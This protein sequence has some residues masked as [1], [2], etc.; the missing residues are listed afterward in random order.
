M[1]TPDKNLQ[2][3]RRILTVRCVNNYLESFEVPKSVAD[4]VLL[5][6]RYNKSL[7]I[8]VTLGNDFVILYNRENIIHITS[9]KKRED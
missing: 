1:V 4:S 5:Q 8:E 2:E 6:F 3:A 7:Y 9:R